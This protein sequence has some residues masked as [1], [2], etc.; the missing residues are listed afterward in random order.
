VVT[1][2][3]NGGLIDFRNNWCA[4]ELARDATTGELIW[5]YNITPADNWGL[6]EPITTQLI[7]LTIGGTERHTAVKAARNGYFYVWDRDTGELLTDPWPFRHVD[8][9]TGV[10]RTTGRA[11]YDISRWNFTDVADR[12]RYT[13]AGTLPAGQQPPANYTGTETNWCPGFG[14]RDWQN[15]SWSPRTGLV[16]TSTITACAT[17]VAI[18]GEYNAGAIY[19]LRRSAGPA[20]MPRAGVDGQPVP[21]VH[22]LQ[23]NDPVTGTTVWTHPWEQPNNMPVLATGSGLLFQIGSDQGVV[24]ALDATNG[25]ILWAFRTGGRGNVSPVTYLGPGGR[26][27]VAFIASAAPGN[28][29]VNADAAGNDAARFQRSGGVLNVFT[30]P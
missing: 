12:R 14:A 24:R 26:Q 6:D 15:D 28:A 25:E 5:A 7:D 1:L 18:E 22:E 21:Y 16:Y 17:A 27:Y 30:L 2:D 20:P 13:D 4:S 29:A 23:A 3:E 19:T 8:F 9:M 11:L 10:D